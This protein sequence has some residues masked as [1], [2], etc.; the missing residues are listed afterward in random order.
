MAKN[1]SI[2]GTIDVFRTKIDN[3]LKG[4]NAGPEIRS[5]VQELLIEINTKYP[6]T[7][8]RP[9]LTAVNMQEKQ[10]K[11]KGNNAQLIAGMDNLP[12]GIQYVLNNLSD[13]SKK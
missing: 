1:D 9:D 6:Q 5:A 10:D 4:D 8:Y 13:F 3:A 11:G 2:Y 12:E 7:A